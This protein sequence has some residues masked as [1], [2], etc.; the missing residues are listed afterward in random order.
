MK[1]MSRRK[2]GLALGGGGARGIAHIG[3]IKVLEELNIPLHCVAGTSVGSLVGALLASGQGWKDLEQFA[4][5]INWTDM[6]SI[7]FP[8]RGLVK[9][10]KIGS[11]LEDLIEGKSFDD[12]NLPF[13]C[14][15]TNLGDGE[16]VIF[17]KGSLEKAVRASCSVPVVFE[18]VE[19]KD[20]L[21]VDGGL[22]NEVPG[23][24]ARD[25]GADY[26][27]AV[28]LND[29]RTTNSAPKHML[30]VLFQS[31]NIVIAGTSQIGKTRADITIKPE[32]QGFGYADLS[33]IDEAM[34][35]GEDAA[36]QALESLDE[37]A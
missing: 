12:L 13:G 18:P 5:E 16:P 1:K 14:V 27:I 21:L 2:I 10:N 6:V 26:V 31:L 37:I 33:R 7:T 19:D 29:D 36:R 30:D 11:L 20:R 9:S 32:L 24:L 34:Q 4:R 23:D 35:R 25:L 28:D 3:V 17:T 15:A 22:V 8:A